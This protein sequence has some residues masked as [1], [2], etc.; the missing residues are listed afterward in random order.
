MEE[1]KKLAKEIE[2]LNTEIMCFGGT[3]NLHFQVR[4]KT[5][6]LTTLILEL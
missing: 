5:E 2:K 4:M 6:K 1:I 3:D